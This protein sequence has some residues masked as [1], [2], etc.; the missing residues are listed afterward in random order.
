MVSSPSR[1]RRA[2]VRAL[3]NGR[4]A[5]PQNSCDENKSVMK[6]ICVA[7]TKAPAGRAGHAVLCGTGALGIDLVPPA[8]RYEQHIARFESHARKGYRAVA[9]TACRLLNAFVGTDAARFVLQRV[10]G[11]RH[12]PRVPPGHAEVDVIQGVTL[13]LRRW[14]GGTGGRRDTGGDCRGWVGGLWLP[15]GKCVGGAGRGG[16]GGGGGAGGQ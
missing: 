7:S 2:S 12:R 5:L 15:A 10:V 4:D 6:Q 9:L 1:R 8:T 3:E 11:V 13:Q 16:G 14:V